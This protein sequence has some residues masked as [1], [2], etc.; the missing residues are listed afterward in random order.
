VLGRV[1]VTAALLREAL[2]LPMHVRQ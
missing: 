2:A 1:F